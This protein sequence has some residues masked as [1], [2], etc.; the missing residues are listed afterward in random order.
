[1]AGEV[2]ASSSKPQLRGLH[3]MVVK[4]NIGIAMGLCV[5]T[6][7]GM[8]LFFNDPRRDAVG[9]FYKYVGIFKIEI[10]EYGFNQI[11]IIVFFAG[12]MMQINHSSE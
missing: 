7:I 1:M 9:E 8:K 12:T 3:H 6:V 11:V 2:A 10:N 4:K 5:A